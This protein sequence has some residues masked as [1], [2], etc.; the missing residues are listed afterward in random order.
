MPDPN[1]RKSFYGPWPFSL[2]KKLTA[3]VGMAR[4]IKH[5]P[6]ARAQG[7]EPGGHPAFPS[8]KNKDL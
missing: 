3:R 5:K 6:Q 4:G 2:L 7:L 1:L 8:F